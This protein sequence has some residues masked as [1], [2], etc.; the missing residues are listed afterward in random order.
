MEPV[1]LRTERLELSIPTT[2]DVDAIYDACQD[3]DTQRYTTVPS[4]YERRHAEEFIPKVAD[5]WA[6]GAHATWAMR[7]ADELAGMIGL[8]R[9]DGQGNGE[10]G[11]WVSPW[12][13]RRGLLTEAANAVIDWGFASDGLD[14]HRVSWRAV[15]GN[16]GS[17]RTARALGF[18]YE[19]TM[20]QAL[21]GSHGRDD[22]W[23]AGLLRTDERMPQL[24]TALDDYRRG[25]LTERR[26]AGDH[27]AGR[28]G[29]AG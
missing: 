6:S 21:V 13:R 3:P 9:L 26:E 8:Y 22:A 24:W 7:E 12:S 15:V 4:P 23:I 25:A 27:A 16:L 14:L 17:A 18:R 19:G 29:V 20:R 5:E 1:T 2:D 11:Y 10:I 28:R